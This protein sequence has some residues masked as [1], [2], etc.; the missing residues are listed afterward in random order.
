MIATWFTMSVV[1]L[2]PEMYKSAETI[3]Q[4]CLC[5]SSSN[6]TSL[7]YF[8]CRDTLQSSVNCA[9][10]HSHFS[11]C[12]SRVDHCTT[13]DFAPDFHLVSG[14][15]GRKLHI[16]YQ[17]KL[18]VVKL[19]IIPRLPSAQHTDNCINFLAKQFHRAALVKFIAFFCSSKNRGKGNT[20]TLT[21][22]IITEKA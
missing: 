9:L 20:D 12:S 21:L 5:L 4:K 1:M 14:G 2:Y 19:K 10:A 17:A 11:W 22:M 7:Q 8:R 6:M 15:H 18:S 16:S 13:Y 3:F